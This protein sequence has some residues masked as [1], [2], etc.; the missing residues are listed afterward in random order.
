MVRFLVGTI[1]QYGTNEDR[2]LQVVKDA[3]SYGAW[4]CSD[5]DS[6]YPRLCAPANGLLLKHIDYGN[7][8]KF[9]W[10]ATDQV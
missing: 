4:H 7:E 3:L 1:V 10:I 5:D 6:S 2:S 8:W 9:D